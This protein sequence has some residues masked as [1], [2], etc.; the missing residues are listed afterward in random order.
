MTESDIY[1]ADTKVK[2][3]VEFI[4]RHTAEFLLLGILLSFPRIINDVYY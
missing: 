4:N 1:T 2:K 3:I